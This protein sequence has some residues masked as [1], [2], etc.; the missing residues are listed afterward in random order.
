MRV[1]AMR[2]E[3]LA[4]LVPLIL[5][6]L[7]LL[8]VSC[9]TREVAMTDRGETDGPVVEADASPE[10]AD[11]DQTSPSVATE[12]AAAPESVITQ[13]LADRR[14]GDFPQIELLDFGFTITEQA[15][16]SNEARSKYEQ[17]LIA[18]DTEQYQR[19][20]TL[21]NEVI[22]ETPEATAAYV[23]LGIAYRNTGDFEQAESAL[24]TASLLS[25]GNPVI[26]NELGMVFRN[27]GR[28]AEARASYEEALLT[29][30]GFHYARRNLGVLCDL[31]L[32]DFSCAIENYR[33]YLDS[34]GEDPEVE[35]WVAD[36]E[37]RMGY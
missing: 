37:N 34:V 6:A 5:A 35:I 25:P 9:V 10:P 21:L 16:I 24:Q 27:T 26:H 33:A 13:I 8:L 1:I 23:G 3:R 12:D 31:Y 15:R 22:A 36:L 2:S 4:L 7:C 32:Q 29:F 20:I 11:S 17:A 18:L 28:F 30:G 14:R 19:G